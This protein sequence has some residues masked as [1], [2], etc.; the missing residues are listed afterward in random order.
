MIPLPRF[1]CIC[2]DMLD[3]YPYST[4]QPPNFRSSPPGLLPLREKQYKDFVKLFKL[5]DPRVKLICVCG[6]HDMGDIPCREA[7][8]VYRRQFGQDYFA[9]WVGGVKFVVLNSQYI[10]APDGVPEETEKQWRW[11][12]TIKDPTA[13]YIGNLN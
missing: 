3:A 5:L 10:F 6:N 1:F 13:K 2:G 7:V 11:M 8:Q 12:D 4:P 9:F